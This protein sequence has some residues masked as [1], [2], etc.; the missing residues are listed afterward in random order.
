MIKKY[1]LEFSVLLKIKKIFFFIFRL[2]SLI[3]KMNNRKNSKKKKLTYFIKYFSKIMNKCI[4]KISI[5]NKV[6]FLFI[7]LKKPFYLKKNLD[8]LKNKVK[9]FFKNIY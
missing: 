5:L 6:E 3:H 4:K 8:F 9:F 2:Y 7:L 1:I